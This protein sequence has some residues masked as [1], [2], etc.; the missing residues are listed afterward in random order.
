MKTKIA[1]VALL[2]MVFLV[3]PVHAEDNIQA[4]KAYYQKAIDKEIEA[5]QKKQAL[6]SSRS[7]N[8]RMQ[9]HREASKALFL[10]SHK[11]I[12]VDMMVALE[13]DPREYKVQK[14]L[15]AQFCNS[16]YANWL[17]NR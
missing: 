10:S 8:L 13:L 5:C 6:Q 11:E 12:L 4:M 14:F 1:F 7:E 17:A 3:A 15:T 9:G 16:C 2:V